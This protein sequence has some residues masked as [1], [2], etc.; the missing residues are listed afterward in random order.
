MIQFL[1]TSIANT[2]SPISLTFARRTRQTDR[3]V[4]MEQQLLSIDDSQK[5][6]ASVVSLPDPPL[7]ISAAADAQSIVAHYRHS[8]PGRPLQ[9]CICSWN[10]DSQLSDFYSKNIVFW[11][12]NLKRY[13]Q[14]LAQHMAAR[15]IMCRSPNERRKV[16]PV[17]WPCC[18]DMTILWC[19]QCYARAHYDDILM[20]ESSLC[21]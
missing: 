8:L 4:G 20:D 11:D 17:L 12:S 9:R 19:W 15:L 5:E 13:S 21:T 14:Q 1:K 2:H 16:A 3:R 18:M 6:V 10:S 7:F